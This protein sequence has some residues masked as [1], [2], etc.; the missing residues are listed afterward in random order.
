MA[1]THALYQKI[2]K[3][4]NIVDLYPSFS[5][6]YGQID[7]QGSFYK[8]ALGWGLTAAVD[9]VYRIEKTG[10]PP[11]QYSRLHGRLTYVAYIENG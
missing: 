8:R 9:H 5:E 3:S 10:T 1:K 7:P 4:T 11:T 6:Q 2:L